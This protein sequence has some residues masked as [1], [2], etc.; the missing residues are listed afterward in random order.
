[1]TTLDTDQCWE[2]SSCAGS[3]WWASWWR[4][5]P[6]WR[7]HCGAGAVAVP[8]RRTPLILFHV[9]IALHP[10]TSPSSVLS[11][12]YGRQVVGQP[13]TDDK[14]TLSPLCILLELSSPSSWLLLWR[15]QQLRFC[16]KPT[17]WTLFRLICIYDWWS[18]S[19]LLATDLLAADQ[20]KCLPPW[21][22][23]WVITSYCL[24]AEPR[25]CTTLITMI[26]TNPAQFIYRED[27]TVLASTTVTN[28]L[29]YY[30]SY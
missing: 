6:G 14:Q 22:T 24:G 2:V 15:L 7:L 4:P 21:V 16:I 13:Q 1:M 12:P 27:M 18:V 8:A 11:S 20:I 17:A 23:C 10:S 3:W 19:V 26:F 29:T 5:C 30:L 25:Y 9:D 28:K